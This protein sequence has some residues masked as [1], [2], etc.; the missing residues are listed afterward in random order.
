MEL[1]RLASSRDKE[2]T[3][4]YGRARTDAEN[5]TYFFSRIIISHHQGSISAGYVDIHNLDVSVHV[6]AT[7]RSNANR[8]ERPKMFLAGI[9][10]S[11]RQT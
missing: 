3:L 6:Q 11:D 9:G 10:S 4:R 5:K 8:P 1:L 7:V 2:A